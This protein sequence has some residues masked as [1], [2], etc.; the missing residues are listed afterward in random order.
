VGIWQ[1][2][3]AAATDCR[4]GSGSLGAQIGRLGMG[5]G[6]LAVKIELVGE[7]RIAFAAIHGLGARY[8]VGPLSVHFL[9]LH[10]TV[11][12]SGRV[13]LRRFNIIAESPDYVILDWPNRESLA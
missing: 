2:G 12:F 3:Y 11:T 1:L 8:I 7:Q 9:D 13:P 4:V 5:R 10:E 6:P